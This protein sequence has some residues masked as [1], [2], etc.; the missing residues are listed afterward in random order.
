M[1]ET[2][3]F[4]EFVAGLTKETI[5]KDLIDLA[6]LYTL[7][8]LGVALY[9]SEKEWS[10]IVAAYGKNIGGTPLCTVLGADWK[11]SPEIASLMNGSMGHAFELDDVHDESLLHP[12]TVVVPAA[13]AVA[14]AN[15]CSGKEFLLS[16]IVGY[17]VMARVG[18][19]VGSVA[20]LLRGFHITGTTGVFGAAAAA[21]KLLHHSLDQFVHAMG[22]AGS[23]SS[24]LM[25]FSQTGGMVKRLHAGRAAQGG[26]LAAYLAR[27]GFTGPTTVF[28]GKYGFLRV[29]SDAPEIH[30]LTDGLGT[31]Y[32]IREIT[33]KPYACCS[34]LHQTIDALLQ[35]KEK[36]TI[37]PSSVEHVIVEGTT[38]LVEQNALDGTH[39]IMAA[40]YSIPFT[41][42]ATLLY[43][44]RDPRTYRDE[45]LKSPDV[46][47]LSSKV[48]MRK[49][50]EFDSLY[51]RTLASRV[52]VRLRGG[53]QH[54][55]T[56]YN[57]KGHPKNPMSPT[58]IEE[59]FFRLTAGILPTGRSQ[60]I[61]D[62]V[63]TLERVS[64]IVELTS[65]L[66]K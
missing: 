20:H 60:K 43:E 9:G 18:L 40:Q 37:D 47:V 45:I 6:K 27:D 12:G 52:T 46:K 25:E 49:D 16:V 34:D 33:V 21:C 8:L 50:K 54:S 48:E 13:I 61:R 32:T 38:K 10:Q 11:A 1:N 39:S 59:K 24:G 5:P 15:Q 31:H 65:L 35:I 29:F 4:C 42:A 55:V 63:M 3:K 26:I 44:I 14:E 22:I 66:G 58:E 56:V 23:L 62:L 17:E 36:H 7:D 41:V 57:S 30:R 64:N 28:E 19:A 51:P 53:Q 2:R